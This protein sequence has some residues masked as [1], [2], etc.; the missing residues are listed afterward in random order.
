[1]NFT[2]KDALVLGVNSNS[3]GKPKADQLAKEM[4]LGF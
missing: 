1:M 2:F 3:T 4:Q